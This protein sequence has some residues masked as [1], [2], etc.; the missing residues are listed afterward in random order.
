MLRHVSMAG[1]VPVYQPSFFNNGGAVYVV[2]GT[3]TVEHA[4]FAGNAAHDVSG[5]HPL[6]S[7][8]VLVVC[9][10]LLT[11]GAASRS[12]LLLVGIFSKTT[13]SPVHVQGGGAI[14]VYSGAGETAVRGCVFENN[15]A[16]GGGGLLLFDRSGAVTVADS[17]F[18]RNIAGY[19]GGAIRA[20]HNTGALAISGCAFEGNTARNVRFTLPSCA[21]PG[22]GP[23]HPPR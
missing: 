14:T 9:L 22:F 21:G 12:P 16:G 20:Y 7:P 15:T 3:L 18:R 19:D 17:S 2:Q 10:A 5:S 6:P 1:L 13:K 11:A 23:P 4:L 8:F